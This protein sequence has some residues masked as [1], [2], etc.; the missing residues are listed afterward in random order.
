MSS[1]ID[2]SELIKDKKGVVSKDNQSCG[3]IIRDDDKNIII[4][5]GVVS[6]HFYNVSKSTVGAYNG[7]ELT[8]NISYE[9]LKCMKTRIKEFWNQL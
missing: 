3:N 4:E 7:A 8:L 6:Q 1:S 5:D 2:W 9:E